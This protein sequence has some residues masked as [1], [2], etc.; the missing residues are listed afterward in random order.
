MLKLHDKKKGDGMH[1]ILR[2]M[3]VRTGQ[4]HQLGHVSK[5]WCIVETDVIFYTLPLG[6]YH[7]CSAMWNIYGKILRRRG[8]IHSATQARALPATTIFASKNSKCLHFVGWTIFLQARHGPFPCSSWKDHVLSPFRLPRS[9]SG[10]GYSKQSV[11]AGG[12]CQQ[13]K[14]CFF[15]I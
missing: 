9:L 14:V 1:V 4:K 15:G 13:G 3:G 11:P 12:E 6:T 2:T 10:P 8:Y 5:R 7:L